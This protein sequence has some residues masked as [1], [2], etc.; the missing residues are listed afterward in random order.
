MNITSCKDA[1]II[2]ELHKN[3]F[4]EGQSNGWTKDNIE[5]TLSSKN[6]EFFTYVESEKPIGFIVL[7]KIL[8]EAEILSIG[9]IKNQKHSGIGTKLLNFAINKLKKN[10]FHNVFLEVAE[11][12][13]TAIS[14]Y[15]KNDFTPFGRRK[16]YY[17]R[18]SESIDA[19]MMKKEL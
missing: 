19:I 8:D 13:K 6:I 4:Q 1:E 3:S 12:N 9:V 16:K 2:F 17:K 18:E 11:D 10:N 5:K 14:F 7:M 15:D